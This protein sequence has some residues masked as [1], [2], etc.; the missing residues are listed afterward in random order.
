MINSI[1][2]Y[3]RGIVTANQG[4]QGTNTSPWYANLRNAAG[5]EIAT[6]TTPA[7]IDPTG[8][9]SQP[10]IGNV[11]SASADSGNPVKI[12]GVYN[13]ADIALTNGQRG[14][15]QLDDLG[16]IRVI[17]AWSHYARRGKAFFATSQLVTSGGTAETAYFLVKNPNGSGKNILLDKVTMAAPQSGGTIYKFYMNPTVTLNGTALTITGGRQT[18]QNTAVATIF[19]LPTVTANGT[20]FAAIDMPTGATKEID[21]DTSKWIEPNNSLL[22]TATQSLLGGTSGIDLQFVEE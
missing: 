20:M 8:T 9:T 11:A 21:F 17:D 12:G 14:D 2:K 7:R 15:I 22:I 16:R 4:T 6:A 5:T 13:S 1:V 10:V 3:V 18:G 19:R